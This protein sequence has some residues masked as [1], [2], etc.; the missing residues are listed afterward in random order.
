[1]EWNKKKCYREH[2]QLSRIKDEITSKSED[3]KY[4]CKRKT[5][6]KE[7][8]TLKKAY[9]IGIPSK[10]L[11]LEKSGGSRRRREGY[12]AENLFKE[13]AENFPNLERKMDVQVHKVTLRHIIM[14]LSNIQN[15]QFYK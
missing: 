8:K 13:I 11:T 3:F 1:M 6:D 4:P 12:G 5:K 7:W 9:G 15:N 14:K 2:Q 10:N